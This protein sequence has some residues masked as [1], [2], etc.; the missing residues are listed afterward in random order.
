M[1]EAAKE[2]VQSRAAKKREEKLRLEIGKQPTT[3]DEWLR[4]KVKLPKIFTMTEEGD[5]FTPPIATGDRGD[6]TIVYPQDVLT[7]LDEQTEFLRTRVADG[8][9]PEEVYAQAKRRLR[10]VIEAYGSG[11]VSTHDVVEA[12]QNVHE[13]E[14]ILNAKMKGSRYVE[15]LDGVMERQLTLNVYDTQTYP[16]P[17]FMEQYT[18]LPWKMFWKKQ[19]LDESE[20][21]QQ[22]IQLQPSPP[23]PPSERDAQAV[24]TGAIIARRIRAKTGL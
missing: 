16:L 20:I 12:N 9:E 11:Q 18:L 23:S 2:S 21:N 24:R 8:K 14:C 10:E 7:T 3:V 19:S 5:L 1:A 17:V 4:A 13:A 22:P 6:L 15:R